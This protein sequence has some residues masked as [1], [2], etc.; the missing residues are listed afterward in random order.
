MSVCVTMP[1]IQRFKTSSRPFVAAQTF[2]FI[3]PGQIPRR[4]L[5]SSR[6]ICSMA[7]S[8]VQF[9]R[10]SSH[11]AMLALSTHVISLVNAPTSSTNPDSQD[12]W[13]ESPTYPSELE[14]IW[15]GPGTR[16][17]HFA[18][19]FKTF[20]PHHGK[21]SFCKSK[22]KGADQLRGH[23]EA[24]QRLC[25]RCT[26]STIPLLSKSEISSF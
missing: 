22:N 2:F 21:L 7:Y 18:E 5:P 6:L 9:P 17:G 13:I 16:S 10:P 26:D 4:P 1:L 8:R 23:C 11:T 3:K 24:D 15:F 14:T 25:F 20:E 12:T 19:I